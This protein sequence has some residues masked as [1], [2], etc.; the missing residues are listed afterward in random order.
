MDYM[1]SRTYLYIISAQV[2]NVRVSLIHSHPRF[3]S[4]AYAPGLKRKITF[5]TL[6]FV[7][8]SCRP[9]DGHGR[10]RVAFKSLGGILQITADDDEFY[11]F[12]WLVSQYPS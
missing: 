10:S 5:P 8:F 7:R 4:C 1:R 9:Q 2:L 6:Y 3:L 12:I 11:P